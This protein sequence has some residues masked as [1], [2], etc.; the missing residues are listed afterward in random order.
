MLSLDCSPDCWRGY[1]VAGN[2]GNY[3]ARLGVGI[4]GG[5]ER[6]PPLDGSGVAGGLGGEGGWC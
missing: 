1:V 3:G 2:R 6:L 5:A 4:V